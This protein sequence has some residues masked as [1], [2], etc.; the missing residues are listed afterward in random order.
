MCQQATRHSCQRRYNSRVSFNVTSSGQPSLSGPSFPSPSPPPVP[1]LTCPSRARPYHLLLSIPEIFWQLAILKPFCRV[2]LN[3]LSGF[4]PPSV[5]NIV[6][7]RRAYIAKVIKVKGGSNIGCFIP[8]KVDN[9]DKVSG[10]LHPGWLPARSPAP[11]FAWEGRLSPAHNAQPA[12]D[13]R[14]YPELVF[15]PFDSVN[16]QDS[17]REANTPALTVSFLGFLNLLRSPRANRGPKRRVCVCM[18]VW[19]ITI[20]TLEI[21]YGYSGESDGVFCRSAGYSIFVYKE[22]YAQQICTSSESYPVIILPKIVACIFTFT[23]WNH[24][25][26]TV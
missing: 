12:R 25:L 20:H 17:T 4:L 13:E 26:I 24:T 7:G 18:T 10:R 9:S 1:P 16:V 15:T 5:W 8:P 22:A 11:P 2:W 23:H 14:K 6:K 21:N 3:K 19:W